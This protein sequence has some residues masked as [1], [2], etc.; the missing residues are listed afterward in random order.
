MKSPAQVGLLIVSVAALIGGVTFVAEYAGTRPASPRGRPTEGSGVG[1]TEDLLHFSQSNSAGTDDDSGYVA[2]YELHARH[3]HDF[4]FENRTP[5]PVNLGLEAAN[6]L[7]C[8]VSVALLTPQEAMVPTAAERWQPLETRGPA[9]QVPAANGATAATGVV[10]LNW[11]SDVPG[12]ARLR[13]KLWTEQAPRGRRSAEVQA[14]VMIVPALMVDPPVLKLRDLTTAGQE[15]TAEFT[16]WSATRDAFPLKVEDAKPGGA[17]ACDWQPLTEEACRAFGAAHRTR[18]RAGYRVQVTV[19]ERQDGNRLDLGPFERKL[20]VTGPADA[21]PATLPLIGAVRGEVTI[22][23]REQADD[24]DLHD[25]PA[26][27]GIEKQV[28][29]VTDDGDLQLRLDPATPDYLKARLGAPKTVDGRRR[30]ELHIEVAAR[31]VVGPLPTD[32]AVVLRIDS[33]TPRRMRLPVRGQ[34]TQ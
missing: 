22:A 18:V 14:P 8:Q 27:K 19:R 17:V 23:G 30:W 15:E 29:L 24:I 12:L 6:P 4:R 9:I 28:T 20:V 21:E 31:A 25:F 34:A 32:A 7:G 2:E 11:K 1:P 5:G 16:C 3:Q 13:V 33:A 10:R 26:A